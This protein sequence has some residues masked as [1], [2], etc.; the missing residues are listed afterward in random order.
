MKRRRISSRSSTKRFIASAIA[1]LIA[2]CAAP[3]APRAPIHAQLWRYSA[4][5]EG[6]ALAIEAVFPL[7]AARRFTI[8]R[9]MQRFISELV[10]VSGDEARKTS[11][12][13]APE[14][15]AS[16]CTLRYRF[17]L[18]RAARV[19]DDPMTAF[20]HNEAVIAP[21]S[22]WLIRPERIP[23]TARYRLRVDPGG[24]RFATG[25]D[26]SHTYPGEYE[27]AAGTLPSA[28]FAVFGDLRLTTL[29][30]GDR[31][32][33]VAILPA[34]FNLGDTAIHRW[35]A[36]AAG[37]VR[38]YYGRFPVPRVLVI[39]IPVA[40]GSLGFATTLGNGGAS[41]VAPVGRGIEAL[42]LVRD[43]Q[44]T[45]EMIHLAFP[46]VPRRHHWL[47]EGISTY[48]EPIARARRGR[49]SGSAMWLEL[50]RGLPKGA[51]G[52]GDRGLDHTRS[53]G[54][55][56]W[57]GALFCFVADVE[58]RKRTGGRRSLDDALRAILDGG[59]DIRVSWPIEQVLETGDRAAGVPVLRELYARMGRARADV[60]LAR[61]FEELGVRIERDRVS[62]DDRAPLAAIREA[63][64]SSAAV[65][66]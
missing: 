2:G 7:G 28:P 32:L 18:A 59:G 9:G 16:A 45:H 1:A 25:I 35:I 34:D 58:I 48:V 5:V 33:E 31:E 4:R 57:G 14:C 55:T 6:D 26:R 38:A 54:G 66:K 27:A 51:P 15:A 23:I 11:T 37:D 41:I 53:W 44:M 24:G 20:I 21:S 47:E 61:L 19:I 3:P 12:L 52:F 42:P 39:V 29:I 17:A 46:N 22:T 63:I 40:S 49:Y 43:W 62:F 13:D 8:E 65:H 30:A 36:E 56:Y 60:D 10:I 64:T 50:A